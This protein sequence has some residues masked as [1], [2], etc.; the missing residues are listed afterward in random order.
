MKLR[1]YNLMDE[2]GDGGA[3]AAGN[4]SLLNAGGKGGGA[5]NNAGSGDGGAGASG[6]A[7]GGGNNAGSAGGG[8]ASDWRAGLPKEMQ[9]NA[10]LKKYTSIEALA[11]AYLNA[12]KIIG[13]EKIP[14]PGKHTTEEEWK[15]IFQK[16]GVPEKPEDYTVKFKEGFSVDEKFSKEFQQHAHKLGILPK[17]A[18]ALADW[19]SD[20]NM[21]SEQSVQAEL[22]KQFETG[23]A[24][25]KKDWGNAFDLNVARAN[26]A[27][28]ELGGEEIVNHFLKRGYG[29]DEKVIRFLAKVGETLFGEHKVVEGQGG[30]G[31][32]T[33]KELDTEISRL[34]KEPAYFDKTHPNHKSIVE[35]VRE[36]YAKR[37]PSVDKR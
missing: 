18:Q 9:E 25:L 29:G 21:G 13:A 35:E 28:A 22:K 12:Q 7:S 10:S 20:I 3:G 2:A 15:A 4:N 37:Y 30:S 31:V 16:L 1:W 11:G 23:V 33:P 6:G 5:N 26:K 32:M 19:F 36:L 24:N 8:N 34:Q 17:Q 27:L 14:V